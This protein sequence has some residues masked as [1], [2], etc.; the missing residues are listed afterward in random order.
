MNR[1]SLGFKCMYKSYTD[2]PVVSASQVGS[3]DSRWAIANPQLRAHTYQQGTARARGKLDYPEPGAK[4]N[5]MKGIPL[6]EKLMRYAPIED[7]KRCDKVAKLIIIAENE[8][9]F[10]N[11]NHGILAHQ[12]AGGVKKLV[13]VKGIKHYGIYYEKRKEAQKLA[14]DWFNEHLK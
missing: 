6:F 2:A 3:M 11:K 9:L 5:N 4:F 13:T 14:L 1:G 8:E 10:D 7:I 12:R